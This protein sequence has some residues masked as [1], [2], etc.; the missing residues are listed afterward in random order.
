MEYGGGGERIATYIPKI[1][2]PMHLSTEKEHADA[3]AI[4]A[5][6]LARQGYPDQ[7]RQ[8]I[9]NLRPEYRQTNLTILNQV[10]AGGKPA[11]TPDIP[12]LFFVVASA[13]AGYLMLR[14]RR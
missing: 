5:F 6:K 8:I 10:I 11:I 2:S 9:N 7:A 13:I 4:H 1:T 14:K 12:I 3:T